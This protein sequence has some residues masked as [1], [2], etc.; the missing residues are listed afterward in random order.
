MRFCLGAFNLAAHVSR[1]APFLAYGGAAGVSCDLGFRAGFGAGTRVLD[2]AGAAASLAAAAI[3][4][5]TLYYKARGARTSYVLGFVFM[6]IGGFP[7]FTVDMKVFR[8]D[9]LNGCRESFLRVIAS[10][11]PNF[12]WESSLGL[13]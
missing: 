13:E 9:R 10:T 3:C 5:G 1:F 6:S 2:V 11:V 12:S 7:S 4:V 8:R